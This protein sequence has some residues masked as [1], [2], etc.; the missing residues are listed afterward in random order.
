MQS[1]MQDS[2][3]TLLAIL[4]GLEQ[5]FGDGEVLTCVNEEGDTDRLPYSQ[6]VKQSARLANV[7]A[8]LGV[9]KGE[10][11]G[12]LA[13]N[14]SD[15]LTAYLAIPCSGAVMHTLNLRIGAEQLAWTIT[16]AGDRILLCDNSLQSK[17]VEVIA[18]IPTVEA[19]ITIGEV[20]DGT[21]TAITGAGK[22]WI[23]YSSAMAEVSECFSWP[24]LD[25]KHAAAIC[26]TS[27]TT[28]KPK[29]VAYSHRS[30]Y[31]HA[32]AVCS[33]NSAGLNS[34]D[35][36]LTLVPMF[37]VNAWGFPYAAMMSGANLLLPHRFIRPTTL[38]RLISQV[39]PT[40]AGAVPTV[41]S[42]LLYWLREHEGYDLSSLRRVICGGAAVP[43]TLIEAFAS[44]H[45][46]TITQGWG[47]TET[48]PLVCVADP[49]HHAGDDA[50]RYRSYAGRILF[51]TLGRI[52]DDANAT[53][54]NDGTTVGELQ[55]SGPWI[56]AGYVGGEGSDSFLT[57]ED[58]TVWL[59]T[60]DIGTLDE[61]GY[62][63]LT[64]RAK[65]V[66][67][68]GGEWISS[69]ALETAL[70]AHPD[71]AEAA[72]IGV[73]DERW[74]ERPLAVIVPRT[75]AAPTIN[76]LHGFLAGQL[77]RWWLPER[78]T[79]VETIQR[80][81]TG[82]LDKL[83]LRNSYANGELAIRLAHNESSTNSLSS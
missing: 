81:G 79:F 17:L 19:V 3:L 39:K 14:S 38:A 29:G 41:F 59:R 23:D 50:A 74:S 48:S 7:L 28:G 21:R 10:R 55:V 53:C 46:V 42:D 20:T 57:D 60:G 47:M 15:H 12:T 34:N 65:D 71:V 77:E 4:R 30:A 51:G 5:S 1:T 6:L 8:S 45:Q 58:G 82:K 25:E 2:D 75:G 68:S 63:K 64:D 83:S 32:L 54:P 67:K 13:W 56:A 73:P 27:G 26:Y 11:I 37:H 76:E 66:I 72:V 43:P 62:V 44:E 80:T 31:L 35:T 24:N 33:G 22:R 40:V 52:V 18:D 9:A 70:V 36:V 49:P 16:H 61:L 69:L 78:W